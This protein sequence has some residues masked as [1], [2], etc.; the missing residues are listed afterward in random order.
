MLCAIRTILNHMSGRLLVRVGYLSS[1]IVPVLFIAL[2][3]SASADTSSV[4][5]YSWE[6]NLKAGSTGA[7][8]LALQKFLNS[9]LETQ[10]SD[11]GAGSPGYESD[12]FG[13]RTKL[14]VITFQEK[15]ASEILTPNDLVKGT[16]TAGVSTRAK[17]NS[18]CVAPAVSQTNPP[19]LDA[20]MAQVASAVSA[21]DDV[22]TLSD[23]GQG[24]PSIAPANSTVLFLSFDL[25]AGNKDVIVKELEIERIG[26]GVNAAFGSFGLYDEQGLQIG[27]VVSLNSKQRAVFRTPF[28]VPAGETKSYEIYANMQTNHS[29]YDS[30][31]PAIQIVGILASSPVAGILPLRGPMHTIN[32]T[33]VVGGA[34]AALSQ[35]DPTGARTRYINEKG[36]KFSGIRITANS[37]EDITLSYIVWTQSGSAGM[38][39]IANIVAV[40]KEVSYPAIISPYSKKEYVSFFEPGVVIKKGD[41]V[42]VYIEGDL[43]ATGAGRTVEFDIR[44]I[45]DE[46]SLTGNQ[47]GLAVWLS[48]GGNTDV[49]EAHSAFL[50]SDGTTDGT[51]VMPFFS[52]SI[53]TISGG[54]VTSV[55]KN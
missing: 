32:S 12:F 9:S 2:F 38:G 4:C 37:P 24:A 30:Q 25:T 47:Y 15:Y 16:G 34:K 40:I 17:L 3:S 44:D 29:S 35:F 50:T 1:L 20:G 33:L 46:V 28:K 39:D 10:I 23:P 19:S 11:T 6:R 22:L 36:V 14:A 31:T 51:T 27:N 55:G 54:T 21:Q 52:G 8:V 42:D 18:L 49:A 5:P 26:L 45:N 7:D 53:T 43:T 41:S 48:P 13:T